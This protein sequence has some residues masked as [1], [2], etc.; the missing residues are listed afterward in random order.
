MDNDLAQAAVDK[1]V[2]KAAQETRPK[3]DTILSV[4]FTYVDGGLWHSIDVNFKEYL[5]I[6]QTGHV[7]GKPIAAVELSVT[8]CDNADRDKV[9]MIYD[10]VRLHTEQNPFRMI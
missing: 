8:D 9:K 6:L 4:A 5:E 2:T 1:V 10:F 7:E 3:F